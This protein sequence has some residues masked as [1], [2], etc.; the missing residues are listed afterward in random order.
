MDIPE[1]SAEEVARKAM[2][3]ASDMCIYTNS[4]YSVDSMQSIDVQ[5]KE[6]DAISNLAEQPKAEAEN[7]K[8][9]EKVAENDDDSDDEDIENDDKDDKDGDHDDITK[10]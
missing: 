9:E 8:K 1:L 7:D 5:S 3:I 4:E 6:A 2:V 10:K